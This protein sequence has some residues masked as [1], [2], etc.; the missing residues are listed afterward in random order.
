[1]SPPCRRDATERPGPRDDVNRVP[2]LKIVRLALD[3]DDVALRI[4]RRICRALRRIG[5]QNRESMI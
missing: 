5:F 4:N 3:T 2:P 1:M